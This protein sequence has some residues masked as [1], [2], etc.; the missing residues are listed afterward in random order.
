M[1]QIR[2]RL[3]LGKGGGHDVMTR[4]ASYK[5]A[6]KDSTSHD[7]ILHLNTA[8]TRHDRLSNNCDAPSLAVI[9]RWGIIQTHQLSSDFMPWHRCISF[10]RQTVVLQIGLGGISQY[11]IATFF[12]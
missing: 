10:M 12:G 11:L 2:R 1:G 4:F 3:G 7:D 5:L 9:P 8:S 6:R